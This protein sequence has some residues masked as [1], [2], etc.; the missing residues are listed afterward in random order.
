MSKV[1][2]AWDAIPPQVETEN[3]TYDQTAEAAALRALFGQS[4]FRLL[5]NSGI[6]NWSGEALDIAIAI[7]EHIATCYLFAIEAMKTKPEPR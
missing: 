7:Q 3:G 6:E 5:G 2:D 4:A 1:D